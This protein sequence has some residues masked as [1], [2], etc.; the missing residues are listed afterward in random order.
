MS[1]PRACVIDRTLQT[2][3]HPVGLRRDV[4][5]ALEERP[6]PL[7][8][9]AVVL[10]SQDHAALPLR[11]IGGPERRGNGPALAPRARRR[12]SHRQGV[13]L[14]ESAPAEPAEPPAK[15]GRAG[16]ERRRDV[17]A[18]RHGQIGAAARA[19]HLEPDDVPR[20]DADG[21]PGRG[22]LAVDGEAHRRA[23]HRDHRRLPHLEPRALDGALER[24]GGVRVPHQAIG[25]QE[26][27]AIHRPRR[28]DA[29][30]LVAEAPEVLDG[31]QE[32][33]IDDDEVAHWMTS[34]ARASTDAGIVTPMA[35]AVARFTTSS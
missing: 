8:R 28:R 22:L 17:D 35:L 13:A 3:P 20:P 4:V 2:I 15:V 7:R 18:A 6:D 32:P 5:G 30:A 29:D 25:D 34:S 1:C 23:G 31:R 11:R 33:G 26:R 12:G 21:G 9:E 27:G 14:L 24:R 19:G 10:R 16:A